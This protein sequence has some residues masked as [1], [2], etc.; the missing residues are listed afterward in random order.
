MKTIM[1][2][3]DNAIFVCDVDSDGFASICISTNQGT[4]LEAE[5]VEE[6]IEDLQTKLKEMKK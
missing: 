4:Y 3:F 2:R 6:L 1:D 5:Q